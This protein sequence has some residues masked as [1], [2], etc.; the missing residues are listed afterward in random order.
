M[1]KKQSLLQFTMTYGAILGV[2]AIIMSVLMYVTG[3]MPYNI[4]R[5]ILT[6]LISLAIM[7]VFVSAGMKGYRDKV[8]GGS[9]SYGQALTVGLLIVIFSTV[10]SSFYSLIFNLYIDPDY[11]QKVIEATKNW[12]YDWMN[13]MGTPDAQIDDAME[14]ID[15]QQA[16]ATPIKAFFQS[17]YMSVIF[18][19][20]LSLIIAA[21]I[22][23]NRNPVA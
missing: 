1:E 19:T 18:G 21:F 20:I 14:R 2:I 4:K 8:L 23:K 13:S 7:I 16:S 22:K 6:A 15:R 10:I 12:T 5:I 9:I 3:Y 11:T 17:L